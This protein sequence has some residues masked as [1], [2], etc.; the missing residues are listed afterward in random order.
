M[1]VSFVINKAPIFRTFTVDQSKAIHNVEIDGNYVELI[2]QSN[3]EK[4]YLFKGTDSFIAH[5]SEMIQ[6]PDLLGLSL[7]STIAKARK[8]GRLEQIEFP[9]D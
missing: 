1:S 5:L 8:N 2:F 6:S 4:A 9:E 7:G 3:T